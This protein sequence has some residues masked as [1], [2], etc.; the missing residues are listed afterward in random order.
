MKYLK[1]CLVTFSDDQIK[2][3]CTGSPVKD[4]FGAATIATKC[5]IASTHPERNYAQAPALFS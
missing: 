2:D 4:M 3:S 5:S 1:H